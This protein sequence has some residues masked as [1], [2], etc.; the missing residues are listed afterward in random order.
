MHTESS[1]RTILVATA[2]AV[3]TPALFVGAAQAASASELDLAGHNALQALYA[4]NNKARELAHRAK[5][6]LIFPKITKLGFVVG[7]QGGDGV[8]RAGH[9]TIGYYEI[10]AASFGLQAG[11]QTF[12][13]ALFFITQSAIDYLA[14]SSGWAIG[15]GPSVVIVDEGFARNM[16]TT[17]LKKDVYAMAFGQKGLMAGLGLEGSKISKIHPGP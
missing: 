10:A 11:V 5:A 14:S 12:S 9:R 4:K 16:N 7:G 13:Y 6:V 2:A 3:L 8:M 1:R 15:T 17:T